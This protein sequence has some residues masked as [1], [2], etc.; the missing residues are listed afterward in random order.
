[1]DLSLTNEDGEQWDFTREDMRKQARELLARETPM[2]LVGI[3]P[4]TLFSAWQHINRVKY[5]W[6]DEEVRRRQASGEVHLRFRCELYKAQLQDGR[7]FL[8]E[9]PDSASSWNVDCVRELLDNPQVDQTVGDQ[10]QYGQ[11]SRNGQPVKQLTGW[12]SNT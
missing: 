7:F 11:T 3:P 1:M 6:T 2:L 5:A 4:C 9:H 10:C 8:H 12:M